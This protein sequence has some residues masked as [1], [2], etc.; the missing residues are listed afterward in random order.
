VRRERTGRVRVGLTHVPVQFL[1]DVVY[2]E[3]PSEGTGVAAGE[4][5]GLVESSTTVYEVAAPVGGVVSAINPAAAT[6]PEEIAS[7]PYGGGWL[8]EIDPADPAAADAH[9]SSDE[10]DRHIA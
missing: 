6:A 9:M 2:V 1:G 8:F 10:Y 5:V 3:L 4:P 7:D